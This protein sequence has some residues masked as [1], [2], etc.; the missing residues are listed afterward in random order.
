MVSINFSMPRL[1]SG[2]R[3]RLR[4]LTFESR[5]LEGGDREQRSSK[6]GVNERL[7]QLDKGSTGFATFAELDQTGA[8][9]AL[10]LVLE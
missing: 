2:C 3:F 4:L 6:D 8:V 10:E 5:S 7:L 9:G 1:T